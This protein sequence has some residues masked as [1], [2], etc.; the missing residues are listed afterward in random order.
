M[1]SASLDNNFDLA[2]FKSTLKYQRVA[3]ADQIRHDMDSIARADAESEQLQSKYGKRVAFSVFGL[4]LSI[5]GTFLAFAMGG[6]IAGVPMIFVLI[7][8]LSSLLY[9]GMHLASS[10]K[11]NV[12][13]RRHE[14]PRQLV[15]FLSA[16]MPASATC[17][18]F[19]D[20]GN[21]LQPRFLRETE[22]SGIFGAITV[23]NYEVPWF[24]LKGSLL[25][26]TKFRLSATMQ[27]K[28]KE[29]RKRKRTK[30]TETFSETVQLTLLVKPTRYQK[31]E[32]IPAQFKLLPNKSNYQPIEVQVTDRQIRVTARTKPQGSMAASGSQ[33]S[34]SQLGDHRSMLHLFLACYHGLAEC[35]VT[36]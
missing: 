16:D 24:T 3:P 36:S 18:V 23:R 31:L 35:T 30:V 22:G 7:A 2:A 27:V 21:Y 10:S 25:D 33:T 6:P 34:Q 29:K 17:D 11:S 4:M 9:S 20:F 32:R 14:I 8:A 5:M 12:E 13:N 28:R 15:K 19:V 1:V 26:G